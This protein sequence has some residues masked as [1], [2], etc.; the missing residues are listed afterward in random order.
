MEDRNYWKEGLYQAEDLYEM[1]FVYEGRNSLGYHVFKNPEGGCYE[2]GGM[3][4]MF[5][6]GI[7]DYVEHR[8]LNKDIYND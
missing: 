1:G 5:N 3:E 6:Q 7:L 8:K 2:S 4:P